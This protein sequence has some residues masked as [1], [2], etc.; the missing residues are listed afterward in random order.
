MRALPLEERPNDPIP[1]SIMD[2]GKLAR[3]TAASRDTTGGDE[4]V[5]DTERGPSRRARDES[6]QVAA[7][8]GEEEVDKEAQELEEDDDGEE[9][10]GDD[11]RE[12][13]PARGNPLSRPSS[14]APS[15]EESDGLS[16][17]VQPAVWHKKRRGPHRDMAIK[18]LQAQVWS[19]DED[20]ALLGAMERHGSSWVTIAREVE[21]RSAAACKSRANTLQR[22]GQ[23]RSRGQITASAAVRLSTR[24]RRKS[25]SRRAGRINQSSGG[26]VPGYSS[27]PQQP[28]H[29]S[30]PTADATSS[31]P[32]YVPGMDASHGSPATLAVGLPHGPGGSS[33]ASPG[34]PSAALARQFGWIGIPGDSAGGASYPQPFPSYML[35]PGLPGYPYPQLMQPPF[36]HAQTVPAPGQ[37]FATPLEAQFMFGGPFGLPVPFTAPQH[38]SYGASAADA[39]RAGSQASPSQQ[40]HP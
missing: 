2:K 39:P 13:L 1:A 11:E 30:R 8:E 17:D 15:S 21:G 26:D 10:N 7:N 29:A 9:E 37:H 32:P 19:L 40:A 6:P 36:L 38:P 35:P 3:R 16:D 4:R 28:A 25:E 20:R 33:F 24:A 5:G 27:S 34:M 23:K 14:G 31:S 18:N 12:D 22:R